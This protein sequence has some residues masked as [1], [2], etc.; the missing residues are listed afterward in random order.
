MRSTASAGAVPG[1][2]IPRTTAGLPVIGE[3]ISFSACGMP[4]SYSVWLAASAPARKNVTNRSRAPGWNTPL[5]L[6]MPGSPRLDPVTLASE[7]KSCSGVITLTV[8]WLNSSRSSLFAAV[9]LLLRWYARLLQMPRTRYFRSNASGRDPAPPVLRT[10]GWAA[11]AEKSFAI[12]S[13]SSGCE[14]AF[15]GLMSS[16]G[17]TNPR[18]KSWAQ[19]RLTIAL[20]KYGLSAAVSHLAST[21]RAGSARAI[22][23]SG[24]PRNFAG[25]VLADS[26]SG[27]ILPR[28]GLGVSWTDGSPTFALM[29]PTSVLK[30]NWAMPQYSVC[31]V[32]LNG[33]LWHWAHWICWPMNSL[34]QA[35]VI[36]STVLFDRK[37]PTAPFSLIGPVAVRMAVAI[38][39]HGRFLLNSRASHSRVGVKSTRRLSEVRWIIRPNQTSAWCRP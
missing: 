25:S 14:Q 7:S 29:L 31:L 26:G 8:M 21:G 12:S 9:A 20:A 23:G 4:A 39:S 6:R 37:N 10:P 15:S 38:S 33:W 22:V 17:L 11:G 34:P 2:A 35:S 5:G 32:V 27:L 3:F 36:L 24:P 28:F 13:S 30:K 1:G 19:V 16:I 18:P